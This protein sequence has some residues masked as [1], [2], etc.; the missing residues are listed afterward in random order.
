M[1]NQLNRYLSVMT[2]T[3]GR[4]ATID[5]D[6]SELEGLQYSFEENGLELEDYVDV[7]QDIVDLEDNII[8]KTGVA[9]REEIEERDQVE[10]QNEGLSIGS[11]EEITWTWTRYWVI[12][13]ELV[14]VGDAGGEFAFELLAEALDCNVSQV[15]FELS[16]IMN[17]YPGQWMGS[18]EDRADNV[19]RGTLYGD[20]IEDD[21][22]MGRA[23]I[24]SSKP[25]IG[26]WIN[27]R[28]EELKVRIGRDGWAQVVSPGTYQ[29]EK[30]LGLVRNVLLNYAV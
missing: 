22:E 3:S 4:I 8:A 29:R 9:A 24:E 17:D 2:F 25:Q 27:Y 6:S 19:Q 11:S 15:R 30:Y 26:P 5:G 16:E 14:V 23:F 28:D 18:F 10:L 21:A 7:S 13:G 12:P 1:L 20:R